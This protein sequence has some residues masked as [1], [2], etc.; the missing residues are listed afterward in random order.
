MVYSFIKAMMLDERLRGRIP[1]VVH[2]HFC[3]LEAACAYFLHRWSGVPYFLT[4]HVLIFYI[5]EPLTR[6]IL[7]AAERVICDFQ[8]NRSEILNPEKVVLIRGGLDIP[9][10]P[11]LHRPVKPVPVILNIGRLRPTKGQKYLVDAC[12][13]LKERGIRFRCDI[14]GE[15]DQR[16]DL[17]QRIRDG[18][19]EDSVFLRGKCSWGELEQYY[20]EA[21]LFAFPAVEDRL[22]RSDGVPTVLLEAVGRGIPV[23][24]TGLPGPAELIRNGETGRVVGEGDVEGLANAIEDLMAGEELRERV[25]RNAWER[26]R[27]LFD[28]RRTSAM[29][30]DLTGDRGHSPPENRETPPNHE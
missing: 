17:E 1:V 12:R 21:D 3:H 13:V 14:V 30:A 7:A 27:N 28:I 18:K 5:P 6:R 20:G 25:V 24:T 23:V 22:G 26:L 10:R 16:D 29:L 19:L 2:A 11:P 9:S 15:G 8:W 4:N